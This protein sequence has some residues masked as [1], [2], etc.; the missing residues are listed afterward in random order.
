MPNRAPDAFL[1]ASSGE[2]LSIMT[3]NMNEVIEE[4]DYFKSIYSNFIKDAFFNHTS[5]SLATTHKYFNELGH[6]HFL[7]T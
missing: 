3:F 7:L 1:N 4:M 6:G 2:K 5:F